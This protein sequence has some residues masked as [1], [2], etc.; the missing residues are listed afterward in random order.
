MTLTSAKHN[1]SLYAALC[2]WRAN[3]ESE[4]KS[5]TVAYNVHRALQEFCFEAEELEHWQFALIYVDMHPVFT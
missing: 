2:F 1:F 4:F 5:V 3:Y